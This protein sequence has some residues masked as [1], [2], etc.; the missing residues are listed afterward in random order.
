MRYEEQ[1]SGS[2]QEYTISMQYAGG[3]LAKVYPLRIKGADFGECDFISRDSL[4]V[5]STNDPFTAME[6][7]G[8]LPEYRQVWVDASAKQGE[9]WLDDDTGTETKFSGFERVEVPAGSYDHCYKTLTQARPE[10]FDTLSARRDRGQLKSADYERELE[11][12]R[13]LI[14]RWFAPG[15]GLVKEQIG[16]GLIRVLTKIEK[17]GNGIE[18][19]TR[20]KKYEIQG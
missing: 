10:L 3:H 16:S 13:Q 17:E 6:P 20:H 5:F 15:V 4:V 2:P 11:N 12:A 14:A 18:D 9:T 1:R 7:R 19:S 8:E